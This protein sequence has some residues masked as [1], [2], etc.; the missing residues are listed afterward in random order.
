MRTLRT[1]LGPPKRTIL[2]LPEKRADPFYLSP[3][4]R[5]LMASI[6]RQRGRICE[7]PDHDPASPRSGIRL[8]GDH[9]I[10]IKDGGARLDPRNVMLRCGTC[11]SRKTAKAR[12]ARYHEGHGGGV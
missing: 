6:I 7:D 4:W 10:E 12:A 3:E 11:H 1:R 5:A 9:V 8:F 2:K